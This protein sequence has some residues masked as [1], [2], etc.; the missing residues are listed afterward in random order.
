MRSL[1]P[2]ADFSFIVLH[3]YVVIV[4]TRFLCRLR[5]YRIREE[6]STW[7]P[8]SND[9]ILFCF[10]E[11]RQNHLNYVQRFSWIF[12]DHLPSKDVILCEV[13]RWKATHISSNTTI[14]STNLRNTLKWILC[15]KIKRKIIN[16]TLSRTF[17]NSKRQI[18]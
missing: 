2:F 7:C 3:V 8:R 9:C 1:R 13:V 11:I 12:G 15:G 18:S 10:K 6:F 4:S 5:Y 17:Q 16:T 14:K